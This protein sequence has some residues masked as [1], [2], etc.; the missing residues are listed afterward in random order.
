ML[1]TT[2]V[3]NK[4]RINKFAEVIYKTNRYSVPAKCAHR[5]AIIELSCDR[6]YVFVD[7]ILRAEH[8]I[9]FGKHKA[10]LNLVHFIDQLSF[11]HRGIVLA[12]VLR[13]R[14][15]H[16]SLQS[17]LNGYVESNSASASKRFM[18]VIALLED[19]TMQEVYDAINASTRSD[20][21]DPAAIAL[22]LKQRTRPYDPDD[23]SLH[24][25]DSEESRN[26][27]YNLHYE[28]LA[29]TAELRLSD[30]D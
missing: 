6:I 4:V 22:I 5:D 2:C 29:P 3:R 30:I 20:T 19:H 25:F 9:T 17:L 24:V 11:E 10:I 28:Q 18:R 23:D 16:H 12:E 21:D 7:T 14:R 13:R 27:R 1:P 8:E 26:D 15:F